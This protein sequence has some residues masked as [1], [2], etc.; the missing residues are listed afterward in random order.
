[1]TWSQYDAAYRDAQIELN[2]LSNLQ[3]QLMLEYEMGA[4]PLQIS[5]IALLRQQPGL[6]RGL[7]AVHL[8]V[9]LPGLQSRRQRL[10]P[11][12]PIGL[13]RPPD[14]LRRHH[15]RLLHHLRQNSAPSF[16]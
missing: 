1:V 14:S 13:Q 3:K 5:T 9:E 4:T 10:L 2:V 6:L 16:I 15:R 11:D 8:P 7:Q 12:V